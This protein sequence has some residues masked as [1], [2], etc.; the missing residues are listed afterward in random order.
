MGFRQ[1]ELCPSQSS[2]LA[3]LLVAVCL[4]SVISSFLVG[5]KIYCEGHVKTIFLNNFG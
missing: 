5:P 4:L 2:V 3:V 1:K